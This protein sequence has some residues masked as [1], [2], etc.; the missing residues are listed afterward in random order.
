MYEHLLQ[1]CGVFFEGMPAPVFYRH[2]YPM[3]NK[4]GPYERA[5]WQEF[6]YTQGLKND[7]DVTGRLQL[8]FRNVYESDLR[9]L[10]DAVVS[11]SPNDRRG[12]VVIPPSSKGEINR[13]TEL[14][15]HVLYNGPRLF[16][17][18]TP[19]VT[20]MKNKEKSHLGGHRSYEM[21]YETIGIDQ[22]A[23]L[24]QYSV[25][26]VIDDV[27][28]SG[29]SFRAMND[30]LRNAGFTGAFINFA[31]SRTIPSE[32]ATCCWEFARA[33][34][35]M[36]RARKSRAE[37]NAGK[38][39]DA[40]VFD[41]DQ[42]LLDDSLRDVEYE[43][44]LSSSRRFGDCHEAAYDTYDG[45]REL[46]SLCIPYAIVSNRPERQI[47]ELIWHDSVLD[48]LYPLCLD[49]KLCLPSGMS[50]LR[51]PAY[52]NLNIH[53]VVSRGG[54]GLTS[55]VL[56][57]NAFS[58]PTEEVNGYPNRFYKP[59][60]RGINNALAYLRGEFLSEQADSRIVGV[61]NTYED[62]VA[63]GAAGIE[64][65]L[66]LW[67]VPD[68]L[69]E[70]A[71]KCWGADYVFETVEALIQWI[72][73][74]AHY[75]EMAHDEEKA[76]PEKA[77]EH[78]EM[79]YRFDDDAKNAAFKLALMLH[80]KD[81]ARAALFYEAA[82]EAG[83][84]FASTNNLA[85]L[86]QDKEPQRAE[87]LFKRAIAAGDER[88]AT[89]NLAGLI[90]NR[91]PELAAGLYRRAIAAGDEYYA[92]RGLSRLLKHSDPDAAANM[93]ERAAG[94]GNTENLSDDL[95]PLVRIGCI[96]AIDLYE[97]YIV[98]ADKRKAFDLALMVS[99]FDPERAKN[100]YEIAIAAGDE[101]SSTN[102]LGVLIM[103]DDPQ[104]AV[105]LFERAIAAGD[106][107]Y[108]TNNLGVL[109]AREDTDRAKALFERSI[110][111]G[112][113]RCAT[114]NLGHMYIACNPDKAVELY[115]RSAIHGETE[116]LL[117][118]AYLIRDSDRVRSERLLSQ[119]RTSDDVD[120][121]VRSL[122]EMVSYTDIGSA[123]GVALFLGSNGFEIAGSVIGAM[124]NLDEQKPSSGHLCFG[125]DPDNGVPLE[126]IL[127][128]DADSGSLKLLSKSSI[129]SMPFYEGTSAAS[130]EDSLVRR[131]L[132]SEFIDSWLKEEVS[133]RLLP[134]DE[135]GDLVTCLS[136]RQIE[137]LSSNNGAVLNC[138]DLR[139]SAEVDWWVRPDVGTTM[140]APYF[141]QDGAVRWR[142]SLL[143]LG[144]RPVI[145]IAI[146]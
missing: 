90:E 109:L 99:R 84:E 23:H 43:N 82:I 83:E 3:G 96:G 67:G 19:W 126:W 35:E 108:A 132:N 89:N 17:D 135:S 48:H 105:N 40:L 25:L 122:I 88:H 76:N 56:P 6:N 53:E 118:L 13:V 145:R 44:W 61:G 121:S 72:K 28:T 94:A 60:P 45:V 63:Y 42:T 144:V 2:F 69:K 104:R 112:S 29:T 113:E 91:E 1:I 140:S 34:S 103:E 71:A 7:K 22:R 92:T 55:S 124:I 18:L 120:E 47:K 30:R 49:P 65:V 39:I 52:F 46:T 26:L 20:R 143:P 21:G 62:M 81:P 87:A 73:S 100:L 101:Y 11:D 41:L 36:G 117:A 127:I 129:A 31:F 16:S 70:H 137:S 110:A 15:R 27:T 86:I 9:T 146:R 59:S 131:W 33:G 50:G 24:S 5:L 133:A 141:A 10:L 128:D 58:F 80:D 138:K 98:S 14:V 97:R 139:T 66:A 107:H 37:M 32:G 74:M 4:S 78:Y 77:C 123:I 12:V 64:S 54:L 38:P 142:L 8:E 68:A 85:L 134:Q 136:I 116:A 114:A 93:L 111:A 125:T 57:L 75:Y 119:A 102:N 79:A 106:E 95:D 130:W 115:E 51:A